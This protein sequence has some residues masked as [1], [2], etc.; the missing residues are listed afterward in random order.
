MAKKPDSIYQIKVSLDNSH[1][2]VWRRIQ[3][4]GNITLLKL[5]DILQIVM[6]WG[7]YHLHQFTIYDEY[8]GDPADDEWGELGIKPEERFKLNQVIPGE[9]FRFTYEYD[10]GDSWDHTLLVEK[11]LPAEEGQHYPVCL[12]GKRAC[13]PEDVGGVW[14]YE[15]FLEAINDPEHAEH[16]EYLEWVGGEFNPDAFSLDEINDRL[17][18]MGRGKSVEVSSDWYVDEE[19]LERR[20]LIPPDPWMKPFPEDLQKAAEDLALRRDVI[21]LLTYLRDN[22]VTGTQ[23]TGNLPLK[24]VHAICAQFVHPPVLEEEIGDRVFRIRSEL[25]V[26]PLYFRH[27]LASLGG[28]ASG[29]PSKRWRVTPDGETFL[30]AA[31][32]LQ[33]WRLFATWWTQVNWAIAAP[34]GFEY[35]PPGFADLTLDLLLDLPLQSA[36][37]FDSFADRLIESSGMIWPIEDQSSARRILRGIIERMAVAPQIDFG[38]LLPEYEPHKILGP[39]YEELSSIQLTPFGRRLLEG[40]GE[41]RK[42]R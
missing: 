4:P 17:R 30:E 38:V 14:G 6:G 35:P 15:G 37:P 10:F 36:M 3:V 18:H 40:M 11:I 2:P 34:F 9:G 27:V 22:R 5:H 8:Y 24:A 20:S 23:S 12:K 33:V 39:R 16:D 29:A 13:P 41:V 7:G 32:A 1:P 25:D 28:L 21:S 42:K 19:D 31:A 26:W